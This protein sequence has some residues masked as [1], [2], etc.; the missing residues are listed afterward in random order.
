[1]NN[2]E[3]IQQSLS[4]FSRATRS[5]IELFSMDINEYI[6]MTCEREDSRETRFIDRLQEL[7]L[8]YCAD[9]QM[10]ASYD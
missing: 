1:M 10:T 9:F 2:T 4:H 7:E 5:R 6:G 3:P 8:T